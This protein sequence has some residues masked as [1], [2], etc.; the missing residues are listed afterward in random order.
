[1]LVIT[2]GYS[3]KLGSDIFPNMVPIGHC[4]RASEAES[5]AFKSTKGRPNV[6]TELPKPANDLSWPSH[7]QNDVQSPWLLF[8]LNH[9]VRACKFHVFSL[10]T[11]KDV[12]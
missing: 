11:T 8:N 6:R 2:R 7:G 12:F 9:G 3:L 5:C 1:M 4:G 10:I